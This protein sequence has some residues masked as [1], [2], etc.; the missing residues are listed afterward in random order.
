MMIKRIR[1][2]KAANILINNKGEVKLGDFGLARILNPSSSSNR[3]YTNRVVTLWY[4]APELLFGCVDYGKYE[5][6]KPDLRG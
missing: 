6:G 5:S 3:K 2:I 1:D 4:R